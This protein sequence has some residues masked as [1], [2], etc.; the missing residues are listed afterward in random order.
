[1][2]GLSTVVGLFE[3]TQG[4]QEAVDELL[5]AGFRKDQI[6]FA[7]H[8]GDAPHL[9]SAMAEPRSSARAGATTGAVMGG[10]LGGLLGALAG[11][12]DSLGPVIVDGLVVGTLG[13]IA[14]GAV[15]GGLLGALVSMAVP[16]DEVRYADQEH[17][18]GPATVAVR[19]DDRLQEAEAILRRCGADRVDTR[20]SGLAGDTLQ[21]Q[22]TVPLSRDELSAPVEWRKHAQV[23]PEKKVA[24]RP[25]TGELPVVRERV[26]LERRPVQRRTTNRPIGQDQVFSLPLRQEPRSEKRP[27]H[28]DPDA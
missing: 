21:D 3:A 19:A 5:R 22:R 15:A 26:I 17:Q 11:G 28:I 27:P 18:A 12:L 16:E 24:D 2:I 8:A 7:T 6:D 13:G 10:L 20:D 25:R 1:M 4:A 9:G 14:V 23:Q